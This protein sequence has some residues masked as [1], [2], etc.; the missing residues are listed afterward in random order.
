MEMEM[1]EL[2]SMQYLILLISSKRKKYLLTQEICR[3]YRSSEPTGDNSVYC[4]IFFELREQE[5]K[6]MSSQKV[7]NKLVFLDD[8]FPS[9][10]ISTRT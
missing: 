5:A 1:R 7:R 3:T 4:F 9:L 8:L 2:E 10:K 6:L